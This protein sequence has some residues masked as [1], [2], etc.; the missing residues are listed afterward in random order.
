M[1][2]QLLEYFHL[3]ELVYHLPLGTIQDLKGYLSFKQDCSRCILLLAI[4]Q[5]YLLH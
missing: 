5:Q 4:L 3:E 2:T 1:D